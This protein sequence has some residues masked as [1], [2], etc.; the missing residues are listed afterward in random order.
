MEMSM[1]KA[2]G[3]TPKSPKKGMP[4]DTAGREYRRTPPGRNIVYEKA[5]VAK[6]LEDFFT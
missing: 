6:E 2:V 1:T 4:S 5:K 3:S